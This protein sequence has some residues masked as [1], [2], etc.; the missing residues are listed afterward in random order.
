VDIKFGRS[1]ID[2]SIYSKSFIVY[3]QNI[4]SLKYKKE[5]LAIFLSEEYNKPDIVWISE[6]HMNE[7]EL[8]NL[9]MSRYKCCNRILS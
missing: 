6:H 7:N 8:P 1:K 2:S 4:R 9:S 3:H 5:E